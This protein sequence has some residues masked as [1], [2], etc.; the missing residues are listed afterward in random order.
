[1]TSI[2]GALVA[3]GVVCAAAPAAAQDEVAAFYQGKQV[4][5]VVGTAAGG[6]Y[7]LFARVVARHIASH[8]PG[9]PLVIVQNLPAAGGLVMTNQLFATA[10][11]D[12]TVI[13]AP[14]NGIPTAPL[15]APNGVRFDAEKLIWLGST[16]RE[17]Y[18]AFVWHTAPVQ[19][20]AELRTQELVV[21]ATAPGTTM[22]DFPLI[23]NAILGTRFKIVRGY[24]G[25]PQIN[26]AIERGEI[27]GQGGIGWAAVKAQVPQWIA[28][29]KIKVIA[30][31]GLKR[32]PD[33]A[34]VPSML[35]L[36]ATDA[37]RRAML[38]L[39]ART[40]YGRPYFVP[41]EVPAARVAARVR[42]DH[43]GPGLHRRRRQ[44]AA[45]DRPDDRR[46][47]AGAGR[48]ARPHAAGCGGPR[49]RRVG[50]GGAV[51]RDKS[52]A[53]PQRRRSL[54][55]LFSILRPVDNRY[56]NDFIAPLVHSV[57][58]NVRPFEKFASPVDKTGTPHIRELGR[59]E[60]HHLGLDAGD[61]GMRGT[62]IS[63]AI[64]AKIRSSSS[65]AAGSNVILMCGTSGTD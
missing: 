41:P 39:F 40:E 60:P 25:T 2:L 30:Q 22:V 23:T 28:E 36:A 8:I 4:R 34:D 11:R 42:G 27:E 24:E 29:N 45:G 59:S 52:A 26:N 5:I 15:L 31:Y 63:W 10:P 49:A 17:P 9:H 3:V 20:L 53:A 12:G 19:T 43:A 35:E 6:G 38:M 58:D 54:S 56:Y 64:H 46:G 37:D 50:G 62:R 44:A 13:G 57:D 55:L 21:G 7:D 33:L 16:N 1:V 32:H 51:G 18:V 61:H 48:R 47:R 14:I 65:L